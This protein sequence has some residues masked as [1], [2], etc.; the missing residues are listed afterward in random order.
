MS[1]PQEKFVTFRNPLSDAVTIDVN[2]YQTLNP[3]E[4][5]ASGLSTTLIALDHFFDLVPLGS[6]ATN[7]IN[8]TQLALLPKEQNQDSALKAYHEHL[9]QKSYT[10]CA[11]YGVPIIGN[12][13]KIG[14][15]I[16]QAFSP[17]KEEKPACSQN[18]EKG[19]STIGR[20]MGS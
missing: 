8:A 12:V 19:M 17:K 4:K 1:F 3:Q 16:F 15:S 2:A 6:T 13:A 10:G 9:R 7:L 5:K 20:R 18:V 14:V 11:L